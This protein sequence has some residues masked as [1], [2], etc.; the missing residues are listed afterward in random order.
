M[1]LDLVWKKKSSLSH[2]YKS[3]NSVLHMLNPSLGDDAG[4][5][6]RRT[7]PWYKCCMIEQ[8]QDEEE[9]RGWLLLFL[10]YLITRSG[11]LAH[12]YCFGLAQT[13]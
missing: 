13:H 2:S 6:S 7:H 11:D 4:S 9:E 10:F 8:K 1:G 12:L 3:S 5:R